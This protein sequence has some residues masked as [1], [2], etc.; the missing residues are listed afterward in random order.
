MNKETE[1][2]LESAALDVS[3][4]S[5][6][7]PEVWGPVNAQFQRITGHSKYVAAYGVIFTMHRK[8]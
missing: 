7:E 5:Q 2:K 6:K 3:E 1:I 4:S 8:Q